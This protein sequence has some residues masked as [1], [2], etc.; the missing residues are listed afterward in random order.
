MWGY[1]A[2]VTAFTIWLIID[3]CMSMYH[4]AYFNIVFANIPS[5]IAMLPIFL[6]RK[7]FR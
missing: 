2:I 1:N 7:Y 4:K 6:T 3:T 5:V